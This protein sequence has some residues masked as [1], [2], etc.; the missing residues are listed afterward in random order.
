M[1]NSKITDGDYPFTGVSHA[2]QLTDSGYV[3]DDYG[4]FP[5][6]AAS[7]NGGV[8]SSVIELANYETAI[9][10]HVFLS[11]AITGQSRTIYHP[12]NWAG[13]S[14]PFIGYSWFI[15]KQYLFE[16]EN[17]FPVDFVYH[18]GSQGGFETF[19]ISVPEKDILFIGLFNKP[20]KDFYKLVKDAVELINRH[21]WLD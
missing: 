10:N 2:Y 3:E 21:N 19:Y 13:P 18:L 12:Q 15:N 14:N 5:T 17:S 20:A 11:E 7:G 9:R 8:W 1:K 4:E 6:F 16:K